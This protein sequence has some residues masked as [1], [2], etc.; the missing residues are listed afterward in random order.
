MKKRNKKNS[1]IER[2]RRGVKGLII[3]WEDTDPLTSTQTRIDGTVSHRNPVFKLCA[4]KVFRDYGEWITDRQPFHWLITITVVFKYPNGTEQLE[5]RELEAFAKLADINDHSLS[6]IKDA[7]RHGDKN[8][9][10]TTR[11]KIECVDTADRRR[12]SA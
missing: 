2:A 10:Q 6:A 7:L 1:N 11:F 4:Q 12:K 5:E 3:E 8:C 9:Y